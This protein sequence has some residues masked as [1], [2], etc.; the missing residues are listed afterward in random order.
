M[1]SILNEN[2]KES[3]E[4]YFYN[5][6]DI[7]L[8]KTVDQELFQIQCK[9]LFKRTFGKKLAFLSGLCEDNTEIEII[10]KE[11]KEANYVKST[12]IGDI[13]NILGYFNSSIGKRHFVPVHIDTIYKAK[14]A[15]ELS[16]TRQVIQK[17]P[18]KPKEEKCI[19]KKFKNEKH[20]DIE[21]C[22]FRH[23]FLQGE[24]EKLLIQKMKRDEILKKVHENDPLNQ[25]SK[26]SKLQRNRLFADFLVETF[27]LEYLRTGSVFD[28]AGGKGRI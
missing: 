1:E 11:C 23:F 12:K 2:N 19:C 4:T 9:I 13:Y 14:N 5:E 16:K 10:L 8:L 26:L 20:C 27:G 28:I 17:N 21:E 3:T 6:T 18:N 7:K 22:P 25:E 15:D 24:E